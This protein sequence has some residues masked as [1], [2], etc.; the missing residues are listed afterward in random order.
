M[1][2]NLHILS[3]L[4]KWDSSARMRIN[5]LSDVNEYIQELCSVIKEVKNIFWTTD[6]FKMEDTKELISV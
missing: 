2:L 3:L 6:W 5:C 1:V 4:W